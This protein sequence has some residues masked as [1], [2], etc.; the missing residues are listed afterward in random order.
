MITFRVSANVQDDHRIVLILPPEVPKGQAELVI[1][2]RSEAG[3]PDRR[4]RTSLA[5]WADENAEHWGNRV[6]ASDVERFTGRR[7]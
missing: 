6:D 3:K 2:V 4:P 7:F 1:S 5:D